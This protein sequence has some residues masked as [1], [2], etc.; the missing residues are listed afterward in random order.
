MYADAYGKLDVPAFADRLWGDIYF[1]TETRKFSRKPKDPE[2]NR[3]FIHFILEPLYKLYS[4]VLSEDTE[5]LTQTLA[6]LGIQLKPIMYK[7][8]TRPLLKA[9]LDQFFGPATGLVDVIVQHIPSPVE[10][11]T[12][13]VSDSAQAVEIL[14]IAT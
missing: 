3:T 12:N 4:Q 10:N 6:G 14:L 8:D 2:H 11:A 13:K 9:I 7:M 1:D 5:N